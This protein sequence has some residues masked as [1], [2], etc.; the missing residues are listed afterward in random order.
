[1]ELNALILYS[2]GVVTAALGVIV[3]IS[4]FA[5]KI[6]QSPYDKREY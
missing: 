1:M 2:V 4:Y 5:Y 6:R 3:V